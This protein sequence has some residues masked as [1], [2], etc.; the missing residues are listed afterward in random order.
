[1]AEDGADVRDVDPRAEGVERVDKRVDRTGTGVDDVSAILRRRGTD[2]RRCRTDHLD[3]SAGVAGEAR[4]QLVGADDNAGLRAQ[5]LTCRVRRKAL[6]FVLN[7]KQSGAP[8]CRT[9]PCRS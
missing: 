6:Q 4:H 9:P 8:K 2:S 1:M 3:C 7:S 5:L